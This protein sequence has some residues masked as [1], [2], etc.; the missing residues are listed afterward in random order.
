MIW[1]GIPDSQDILHCK[2]QQ[3][4]ERVHMLC[5]VWIMTSGEYSA[6]GLD[7][8]LLS[9]GALCAVCHLGTGC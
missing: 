8:G 5:C 3:V 4:C 2:L 6:G 7:E 9:T 1:H